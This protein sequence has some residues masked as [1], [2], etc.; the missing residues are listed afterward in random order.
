[1]LNIIKVELELISDANMYFLFEKGIR[2]EVS[3]SSKRYHPVNNK[4][5]KCYDLKQESKH[6][7]FWMQ[8]IY[9]VMQCLNFFQPINS[10]GLFLKILV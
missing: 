5:L 4:Y 6:I 9:V 8:I 1:M 3:Y 2:E 10:N 7:I